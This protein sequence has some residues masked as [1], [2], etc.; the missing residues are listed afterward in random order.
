MEFD[1][2]SH[3][4]IGAAIEVHKT[5]GPGLLEASYQK[6]LLQELKL[7]NVPAIAEYPIGL[8][9]KGI[10]L[11]AGF[12]IDL[13]VDNKIIVEVKS[14]A[15]FHPIHEAQTLT[16]MKLANIRT[17]ILLNFNI[18]LLKHGIKRYVC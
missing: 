7:N 9:Y 18:K 15:D 10:V 11:E 5:P 16:Y 17:A 3:L 12:R 13:L 2:L 8:E 1:E 14:V 6:C 4:V